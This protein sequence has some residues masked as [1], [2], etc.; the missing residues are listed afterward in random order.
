MA[1]GENGQEKTKGT[2]TEWYGMSHQD[3]GWRPQGVANYVNGYEVFDHGVFPSE[4]NHG[5]TDGD[6]SLTD[7]E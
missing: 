4:V 5:V 1:R 6:V 2:R 7:D 3:Q